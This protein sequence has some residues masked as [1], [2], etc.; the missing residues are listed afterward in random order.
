MSKIIIEYS[1]EL[2]QEVQNLISRS[3]T[4]SMISNDETTCQYEISQCLDAIEEYDDVYIK[5]I[6][7]INKLISENVSFLEF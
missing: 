5:E 7:Y 4:P 3:I 1:P 2:S 6:K